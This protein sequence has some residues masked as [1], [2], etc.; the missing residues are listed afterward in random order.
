M[1]ES[2]FMIL[3][4]INVQNPESFNDKKNDDKLTIFLP[5]LERKPT[6]DG[7]IEDDEYK[8][9][10]IITD[11]TE[12]APVE[13]AKPPVVTEVFGG[14]D[15]NY[16]YLAVKCMD[17]DMSEL[18]ANLRER[19]RCFQDD[20]IIIYL[21]TYGDLSD[22]YIFGT[23]PKGSKIDGIRKNE[24]GEEDYDYDA[25]WNVATKI[26]K[27]YWI[28]EFKIPFSSLQFS[29]KSRKKWN[30]QFLRLRPREN[31]EQ[32]TWPALSRD[33][34][35]IFS[36][37][38][39]FIIETSASLGKKEYSLMPY[40]TLTEKGEDKL[41]EG[42]LNWK[43][44]LS[45]RATPFSNVKV[46]AAINPDF[47]EIEADAP[48][49]DVNTPFAV[50]YPEKRPLFLEGKSLLESPLDLIYT[51]E[52]NNPSFAL[53][54]FGSLE[55]NKFVFLSARDENTPWIIPFSD[56]STTINSSTSSFSNVL[57]IQRNVN[58]FGLRKGG[59]SIVGRKA[60]GGSNTV[61][62]GDLQAKLLN[63]HLSLFYQG[64]YSKT[65]EPEDTTL[66]EGLQGI[67]FSDYT[68]KFDGEDFNGYAHLINGDIY[69]KHLYAGFDFELLSP[70]FRSDLGFIQENDLISGSFYLYPVVYPN[71]FGLNEARFL[72]SYEV[73]NNFDNEKKER[74]Y[75]YA[76]NLNLLKQTQISLSRTNSGK[77]FLDKYYSNMGDYSIYLETRPNKYFSLVL[78]S[79]WGKVI[80]YAVNQYGWDRNGSISLFLSPLS[81]IRMEISYQ[82][83]QLF[84]EKW[85]GKVNDITL[86][87]SKIEYFP[88]KPFSIRAEGNY[89]KLSKTLDISTLL[90][91]Q[92]S[93][94]TIFY[95]GMNSSFLYN[96][97]EDYQFEHHQIFLKGQ[98]RFDL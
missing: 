41:A 92:P 13:G 39:A 48:K 65:E 67:T 19:D 54:I 42:E 8:G 37:G 80:N 72:I 78:S 31:M 18:R 71:A 35:Y 47:A 50:Y 44:G 66:S 28:A 23:N 75:S 10:A 43:L 27:K 45:A 55:K 32:Y 56:F 49:L 68:G 79:R 81:S 98:Y 63:K 74:E 3:L 14:Y 38:G 36:K 62:S 59:I 95:L 33:E 22:A 46:D 7:V 25:N 51:R 94:F 20:L 69:T 58:K 89:S 88:S 11:F 86:L 97:I 2:L 15:N 87:H 40:L 52:I 24:A 93:P 29:R 61:F 30:V 82:R 6:V 53:K 12:F 64:A 17:D 34:P 5:R 76:V 16:L 83:Y 26:N 84:R 4:L 91:Y 9:K 70:T 96:S 77:K 90:K 73:N 57:K 85:S 1:I 21:D 60:S